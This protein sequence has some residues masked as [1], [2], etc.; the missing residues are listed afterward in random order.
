MLTYMENLLYILTLF[1]SN[2]NVYSVFLLNKRNSGGCTVYLW[3]LMPVRCYVINL[4]MHAYILY[5]LPPFF[6]PFLG[7]AVS[8][9]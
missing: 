2:V 7:G 3:Y 1:V 4:Y 5:P 9:S 6:P 8:S